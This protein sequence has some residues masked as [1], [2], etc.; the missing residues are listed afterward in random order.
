MLG[1]EAGGITAKSIR[2]IESGAT[3]E[4]RASTMRALAEALRVSVKELEGQPRDR[5]PV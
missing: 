2:D 1:Y 4:P 3:R 5:V